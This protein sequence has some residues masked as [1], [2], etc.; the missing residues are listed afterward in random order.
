M[1]ALPQQ[2]YADAGYQ[3]AA[4]RPEFAGDERRSRIAWRTAAR[5][6]KLKTMAGPDR[7]EQSRQASVRAK[8]E[9]PYLI[10]KRDFGLIKTRYRGIAKNLNHLHVLFAS[11]NSL[12]RVRA[13]ALTG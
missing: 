11:T 9:H 2:P 5:K 12:T 13:V 8:V 3:G 6:G 10:V 1:Y 7:Q 4:K